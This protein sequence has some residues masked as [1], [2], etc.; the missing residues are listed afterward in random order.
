[1]KLFG[2]VLIVL[3][4]LGMMALLLTGCVSIH[5]AEHRAA[6]IHTEPTMTGQQATEQKAG[7]ATQQSADQDQQQKNRQTDKRDTVR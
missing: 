6:D 1:M 2:W 4:L 7:Q 3:V 5:M